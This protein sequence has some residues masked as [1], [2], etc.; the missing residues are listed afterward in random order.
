MATNEKGSY[1]MSSASARQSAAGVVEPKDDNGVH[2]YSTGEMPD[3]H[4]QQWSTEEL[5]RDFE[6]LG[7]RAPFVA[8]RRRSDGRVGSLQF[9]HQPRVYF[10]WREY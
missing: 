3:E 1:G 8:V 9:N 7:F 2:D 4:E 6:V 5:R 10:A